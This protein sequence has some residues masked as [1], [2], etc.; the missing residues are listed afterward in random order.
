VGIGPAQATENAYISGK[1]A[2]ILTYTYQDTVLIRLVNQP[3][4]HPGCAATHFAI[5][6]STSEARRNRVLS[7]L[8]TAFGTGET[9]V[10]GYDNAGN[11][12]DGYIR[13]ERVG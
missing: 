10:I 6:A 7:R 13:L 5:A 12:A 9:V 1:I 3:T 8:I 11:C 2:A 4:S